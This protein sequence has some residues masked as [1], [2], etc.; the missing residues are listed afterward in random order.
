MRILIPLHAFGCLISSRAASKRR[1]PNLHLPLDESGYMVED[2]ELQENPGV[3]DGSITAGQGFVTI[4]REM[5]KFK[6]SVLTIQLAFPDQDKK[7]DISKISPREAGEILIFHE[8]VI[9]PSPL[10]SSPVGSV[11]ASAV[12]GFAEIRCKYRDD[13]WLGSITAMPSL[14]EDLRDR[15]L[16]IQFCAELHEKRRDLGTLLFHST[17]PISPSREA[18]SLLAGA[19]CTRSFTPTLSKMSDSIESSVCLRDPHKH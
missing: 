12:G 19:T 6:G 7:P 3:P 15:R 5:S 4:H 8:H 16:V 9:T 2:P 18:F 10:D 14:L 11:A 17:L 13:S 1:V